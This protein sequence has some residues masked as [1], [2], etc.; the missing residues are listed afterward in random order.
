MQK[1]LFGFL[2]IVFIVACNDKTSQKQLKEL[3]DKNVYDTDVINKLYLYD[4]I[5]NTAIKN[6]DTIFKYKNERN[7]ISYTDEEGVIKERQENSYYYRFKNN[8]D[9]SARISYSTQ[10][11]FQK[12]VDNDELNNLPKFIFFQLDTLFKTLGEKNIRYFELRKDSSIEIIVKAFNN[13][14]QGSDGYD[15]YHTLIWKTVFPQDNEPD[16]LV[17]DTLIAPGW[18]YRILVQVHQG[19]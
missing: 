11:D 13:E 5:K 12:Q 14:K 2:F 17:K 6:I 8:Q 3:F 15:G 10:S 7:F 18:T 9:N 16:L 1:I 4:S 19:R